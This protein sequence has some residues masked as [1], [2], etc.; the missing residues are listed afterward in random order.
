MRRADLRLLA[1]GFTSTFLS[2]F[3]QTFF[4]GLFSGDLQQATG[5]GAGSFGALYSGATLASAVTIFWVGGLIDR[6]AL[7]SY[8]AA[9]VLLLAAGCLVMAL[10]DGVALLAAALFLLRFAGQGLMPHAA[11]TTVAR[12][13]TRARGRALSTVLVGHP[14]GEALLPVPAVAI[15]AAGGRDAVWLIASAAM[16]AALPLLVWLATPAV[17]AAS[18]AATAASSGPTASSRAPTVASSAPTAA[19]SA[20]TPAPDASRHEVLRDRRFHLLLPTLL[21]PG[22]V[23]TGVLIHQAALVY[24]KGWTAAWFAGAIAAFAAGQITGM[25]GSGPLID[26]ITARRLVPFYLLPLAAACIA[27]TLTDARWIAL[28]FMLGMGITS[29]ASGAVS[30]ALWAELYGVKHLGAIRALAAS[31]MVLST[32]LAPALFGW[33]LEAGVGFE[34][35]LLGCAAAAAVALALATS[36]VGARAAAPGQA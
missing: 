32:A 23:V 11:V 20:P 1:F 3:G 33:L 25:V 31:T 16:L 21:L 35:L 30:T 28:P 17:R 34:A 4:I 24:E 29:G 18:S 14:A 19:S 13:F 9:A 7:R 27:A 26:R 2:G 5:L 6:V 12:H 22:F 36:A 8:A 10:A 15:A